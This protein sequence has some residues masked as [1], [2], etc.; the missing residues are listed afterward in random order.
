MFNGFIDPDAFVTGLIKL[1][2]EYNDPD[3]LITEN[4]AGYGIK[5]DTL[6]NGEVHDT[7]RT[8]Y[9]QRH[10][11]AVHQALEKGVKIKGYYVWCMFDNLE[12]FSG[13]TKRFGITYV[14]FKTQQR[15]PKESYYWYQSFLKTQK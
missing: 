6:V 8:S 2:E 1:K 3:I 9:L 13:Y 15:I 7:L 10:I 14:D 12:W 5:D 11:S 4:G